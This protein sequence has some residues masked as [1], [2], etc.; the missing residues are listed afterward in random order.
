MGQIG[1]A[2]PRGSFVSNVRGL[3]PAVLR[4]GAAGAVILALLLPSALTL[5]VATPS[6][7]DI[8]ARV[9]AYTHARGIVLLGETEVPTTLARAVVATEDERFYSH[10]GIDSLG[11]RG[12]SSMT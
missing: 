4:V 8:Q 12:R 10:H 7:S 6:G 3:A 1:N 9:Q 2:C 5:W 11:W